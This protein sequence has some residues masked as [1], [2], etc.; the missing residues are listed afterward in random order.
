MQTIDQ[1]R[2]MD[3]F[4]E[5]CKEYNLNITPQRITIYKELLQARNHPSVDVLFKQVRQILP[6][7]SFDTVNRTLITFSEI[8]IIDVVEGYGNPK[9]FDPDTKRHHHFWCTKCNKI[10]DIYHEAWDDLEVP[11]DFGHEI[12]SVH[13]KKVILEGVCESCK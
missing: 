11:A 2:E 6:N 3:Y 12:S 1:D 13:N 7:I 9:R 4:H 8:G 5:K 10:I